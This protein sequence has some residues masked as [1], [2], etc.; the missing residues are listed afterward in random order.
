M[1]WK[2]TQG[3]PIRQNTASN[4]PILG[5]ESTVSTVERLQ[6]QVDCWVLETFGK[7]AD[8]FRPWFNVRN[9]SH[10]GVLPFDD[11]K[12][13]T[14]GLLRCPHFAFHFDIH[15]R[16]SFES[17]TFEVYVCLLYTSRCV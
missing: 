9:E 14:D 17:W 15:P 13:L 3:V 2:H 10:E 16:E 5:R 12:R 6:E 7:E 8:S 1:V 11:V 4:S